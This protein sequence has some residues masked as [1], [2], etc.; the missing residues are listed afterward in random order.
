MQKNVKLLKN[1][2]LFTLL[3]LPLCFITINS[4]L[5]IGDEIWNFQNVMKMING[6]KIYV[7][8][9]VII[10][11]IFYY[12][13]KLFLML[14]GANILGFRIYNIVIFFI[15]I[16]SS[17]FIFKVLK[18]DKVKSVLYSLI[19]LLFVMPYISVG[20]NYNVLAIA[21]YLI[22]SIIIFK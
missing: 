9:N 20:A 14:F 1:I 13:G 8:S 11:P 3:L 21:F 12:I 16:L 10:T 22:R 5:I 19:V 7:D 15:L 18:I 2:F 17:F 4:E 6:G